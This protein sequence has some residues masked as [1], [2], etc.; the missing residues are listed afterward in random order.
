MEM[1]ETMLFG[2]DIQG[3]LGY[4]FNVIIIMILFDV[5]TGLLASAR[6]KKINSSINFDG[7]ITKIGEV[8]ALLF[9]AFSD[10][11]LKTDGTLVNMGAWLLIAYEGISIIENFSRIGVNIKFVTKYFDPDKVGEV[12]KDE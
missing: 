9:L 11:Y 6:E 5:V 3:E 10:S 2:F 1:I 7:V 12:K 8:V 4:L